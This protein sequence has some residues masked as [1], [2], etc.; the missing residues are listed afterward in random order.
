VPTQQL[1]HQAS[2]AGNKKRE[3]R[4]KSRF[5]A[6][7]EIIIG[8]F[9]ESS[10]SSKKPIIHHNS[11]QDSNDSIKLFGGKG[12]GEAALSAPNEIIGIFG[13]SSSSS[14]KPI[15]QLSTRFK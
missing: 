4:G 1:K 3:V 14:K 13:E 9:G 2:K 11:L 6:P 12:K 10:S 5:S 7:N 8:I 15:H